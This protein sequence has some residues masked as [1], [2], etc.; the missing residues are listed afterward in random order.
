MSFSLK[1]QQVM[2][3]ALFGFSSLGGIQQ[4]ENGSKLGVNGIIFVYF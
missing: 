2:H 4:C 3:W 1:R